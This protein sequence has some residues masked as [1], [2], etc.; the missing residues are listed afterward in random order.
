[1]FGERGDLL[2][3]L[4]RQRDAV[5]SF[6]RAI[7]LAPMWP[8]PHS[9][10]G[11]ALAALTDYA[12]AARSF[13]RALQ[14]NPKDLYSAQQLT[15]QLFEL[16]K[17]DEALAELQ[18]LARKEQSYWL[19]MLRGRMAFQLGR[20]DLAAEELGKVAARGDALSQ[21]NARISLAALQLAEGRF[22]QAREAL[23]YE[24][25]EEVALYAPWCALMRWCAERRLLPA[26]QAAADLRQA[27]G[28]ADALVATLCATC[29][30]DP[31][32]ALPTAA[33]DSTQACPQLF[34]AAWRALAEGDDDRSNDLLLRCVN[35]GRKDYQQW[36]LARD[37]LHRRLGPDGL[38]AHIGARLTIEIDQQ[39]G[40][41]HAVVAALDEHG[42]AALQG[43]MV[44]DVIERVADLPYDPQGWIE[45]LA[46]LRIGHDQHLT[47]RRGDQQ[48][49]QILRLGW[50]RR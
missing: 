25:P 9:Q 35:T 34:F 14:L 3:G 1:M 10:R 8:N 36:Q 50:R 46:T 4:G 19:L 5:A 23:D 39:T 49:V 20:Y 22:E 40:A 38:E 31:A 27:L 16:G 18:R 48:V 41:R 33:T 26:E 47:I 30:D 13:R 45:Q 42:A 28:A 21:V 32:P 29:L 44:G 2:L 6:D 17:G 11:R 37:L 15:G 12:G 43:L 24:V 7:E